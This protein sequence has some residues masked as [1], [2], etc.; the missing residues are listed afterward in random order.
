M[1]SQLIVNFSSY[2][3]K[4][5]ILFMTVGRSAPRYQLMAMLYPRS[6]NLQSN[7]SEY[8][9]VVVQLCHQLLKFSQKSMFGQLASS[10]SDSD[11]KTYQSELELRANSIK[12]EMNLLTSQKIVE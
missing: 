11:M 9:L 4:L 8:F 2:F 3:E 1:S 5:S 6:K 7:L 10:L 12:E